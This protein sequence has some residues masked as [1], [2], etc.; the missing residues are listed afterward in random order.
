M[1]SDKRSTFRTKR[2]EKRAYKRRAIWGG[3]TALMVAFVSFSVWYGARLPGV[4]I[5]N[6]SVT[7][8]STVPHEAVREKVESA[9]AGTYALL[10][11]RRFSFLYPA[12]AIVANINSI[13]RVHDAS[14]IRSSRNE[15]QIS[16]REYVPYALWCPQALTPGD[17]GEGD[18]LFVDESGFA[19]AHAP[20]LSGETLVRFMVE[21]RKPEEGAYVYD[22]DTLASY[23]ALVNAISTEHEE[24][25][26]SLTET[27]DGDLVLHLSQGPD[28]K[29]TKGADIHA[30]F[31]NLGSILS[32]PEYKDVPLEEFEYID[33]RFGNKVY[34]K[35]KGSEP[36]VGVASSTP[37]E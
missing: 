28:L 20:R 18:C 30:I 23:Q 31:E 2:R 32:S 36:S 26:R 11:P 17:M 37:I 25:L 24:R 4:T 5:D 6:I 22:T 14:V 8:G 10:I 7:G 27:K 3:A 13:P 1:W 16:F 33:L 34:V 15:L 29:I 35:R 9:L 21:G 19:F 12:D